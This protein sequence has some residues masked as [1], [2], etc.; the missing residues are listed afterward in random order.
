MTR[1]GRLLLALLLSTAGLLLPLGALTPPA[2]AASGQLGA[3]QLVLNP[4]GGRQSDGSDGLRFTVNAAAPGSDEEVF[5]EEEPEEQEY[6]VPGQ[7]ALFY[8]GTQQYCCSAGAPGLN[9]GGTAFGQAGPM[10]GAQDW[11]SLTVLSTGGSTSTGDVRTD[12]TGNASARVRYVA[13]K[14]GREYVVT[15]TLT[16]TY[17]NDFVTESY[18]FTIPTGNTEPVKFYLGGDT[19]PGGSDIGYGVMLTSPVRSVISLNTSSQIQFGLRELPESKPFDGATAQSFFTPY[20]VVA[21]GGDIGFVAESQEH[22]AGLMVQWN[23]GSTPGTQTAALQQFAS[24]QGT[25]LSG[26]FDRT[27]TTAGE[28]VVLNLSVENTNLSTASALGFTINLPAGT[29]LAPGTRSNTCGGTLS[30]TEGGTAVSLS[31]GAVG[32]VA[33]CVVGVPVVASTYGTFTLSADNVA[34]V[35]GGLNNNVGTTAF[36]VPLAPHYGDAALGDLTVGTE[37]TQSVTA[38]GAPA[39]TYAVTAG[40]LPAGLT[41]DGDTGVVSGTPTTAGPYAFTVTATNAGGTDQGAFTGTVTRG[42]PGL[43]ASASPATAAYGETVTLRAADLPRGATGTLTFRSGEDVLCSA[44]LPTTSCELETDLDPGTYP[45]DVSYSGDDNW[46]ARTLTVPALEV[47]RAE[48]TL[49]GSLSDRTVQY[50]ERATVEVELRPAAA[51]GTVT[52]GAGSLVLCEVTLPGSSCRT[53]AELPVGTH[54][55][56]LS[57]PGDQHHSAAAAEAGTLTVE[58]ATPALP[59]EELVTGTF[60]TPTTVSLPGLPDGA[61]GTVTVV[62]DGEPA[63]SYELGAG[64]ESCDLPADVPAGEHT[65]R[66]E[67]SGDERYQPTTRKPGL[68]I[69]RASTEVGAPATVAGT[70]GSRTTVRATGLPGTATG[71]VTVSVGEEVLCRFEVP[72]AASC[73]LPASLPAGTTTAVV[74]YSG[75]ENH[76]GSSTTTEL[77][78]ERRA[79]AVEV[80]EEVGVVYGSSATITVRGLPAGAGGV[81]TVTGGP[82]GTECTIDLDDDQ[83]SCATDG[84]TAPGRYPLTVRYAG[85]ANHE[86]SEAEVVLVVAQQKTAVR[87]ADTLESTFGTAATVAV[88][89]LPSGATGTVAVRDGDRELCTLEVPTASSCDLPADLAAGEHELDVVYSG[90]DNFAGS[91]TTTTL[92][93]AKLATAIGEI[94]PLSTLYGENALVPVTGLPLSATGTVTVT[95]Q[96]ET[97]AAFVL[98]TIDLDEDETGCTTDGT[99]PAGAY[100]VLVSYPGDDNHGGATTATRWEVQQAELPPVPAETVTSSSFGKGPRVK[101]AGLK[102]ATGTVVVTYAGPDGEQLPFCTITLPDTSCT[103]PDDLPAGD[104]QLTLS[105]GGDANHTPSVAGLMLTVDPAATQVTTEEEFTTTEGEPAEITVGGLPGEATGTVTVAVAAPEAPDELAALRAPAPGEVLCT[106]DI[107]VAD[108]CA[109][110]AELEAGSYELVVAYDGDA[111]HL[112][113]QTSTVLEVQAA[114]PEPTQPAEPEPTEPAEP[115]TAP[116]QHPTTPAPVSGSGGAVGGGALARTGGPALALGL[117]G[118]LLLGAGGVALLGARRRGRA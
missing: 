27:F 18:E 69:E 99:T 88:E 77:Q 97:G 84:A 103:G 118:L 60:G 107:A 42:N 105:Y 101:L 33:N 95:V 6:Y 48:A 19:A 80:D 38:D 21:S 15:R 44:T 8:R 98:C 4:G 23:L 89:N 67:Y 5:D 96:P 57:Y 65:L 90:D 108:S 104:Y 117:V 70:Y 56:V 73:D 102:D 93:V 71:E 36:F 83:T 30:A 28:P 82:A 76:L 86:P 3:P 25:N 59:P 114:E 92:T 68:L 75:D 2:S 74:T 12:R 106:I 34:A 11:T 43:S 94:A 40:A 37:T 85:D 10:M 61:T 72:G 81:V 31:D 52:V 115:G 17:P 100:D 45:L 58:R 35:S 78:I 39:P 29:V 41:L 66:L 46:L 16:Y 14:E 110:P 13:T 111:N 79:T 91:R 116:V 51:T 1:A 113:S 32:A 55:L 62:V 47:T 9:V 26:G 64:P 7:D 63:C 112:G 20:Q 87:T 53:P 54:T 22:D 24:Q 109:T 50:G 49:R